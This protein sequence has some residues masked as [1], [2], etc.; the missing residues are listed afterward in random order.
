MYRLYTFVHGGVA[1]KCV[2]QQHRRVEDVLT[3]V[4]V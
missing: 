3:Y 2:M 4:Y 1:I